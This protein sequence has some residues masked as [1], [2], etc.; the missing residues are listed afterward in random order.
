MEYKNTMKQSTKSVFFLGICIFLAIGQAHAQQNSQYTQYMYHMSSINPAFAGSREVLSAVASYRTQWVGLEGAPETLLFSANSPL[1]R[2]GVG[3]GLTFMSDKIG[4]SIENTI[5]ADFSYTIP[6]NRRGLELS[7]GIKA[8][9]HTLDIDV[10]KLNAYDPNDVNLTNRNSL[11]PMVGVGLY[12]HAPN[13][14]IGVSTPNMLETKH[15]NDIAVS[16]ATEK[17]HLYAIA[18]YIWQLNR[19][20]KFKPTVLL[21]TVAN[22]PL[23]V[24]ISANFLFSEKLV[25]GV[26]YRWDAAV[27]ALTA[28]Q[29]TD[30]F[31]VGYSYDFAT[32]ELS[33]YN[34][35]SHEIFLRFELNSAIGG[36]LSP[37]YF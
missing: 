10:S 32:S 23:A 3:L 17:I 7:F 34:Y 29:I 13:W 26:A 36:K 15:Y 11:F 30:Q 14:Y 35:G 25:F 37:W 8:G 4:P 6:M 27:S 20:L 24:D 18:G 22:A 33:N 28:F 12:L 2:Q 19:N 31:M 21:K 1:G 16:T 9:I 5:A